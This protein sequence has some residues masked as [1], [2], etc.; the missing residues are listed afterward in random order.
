MEFTITPENV[1]Q[2]MVDKCPVLGI[3][4]KPSD[5]YYWDASPSLDRI[6]SARGYT[7][8]NIWVISARA[9]RIKSDATLGE[10]KS[11]VAALEVK[12]GHCD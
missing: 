9:N 7:P 11:L 5:R 4:L 10:L 6:D 12:H 2:A 1:Y 8:D 3:D